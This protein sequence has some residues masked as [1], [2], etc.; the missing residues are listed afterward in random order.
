MKIKDFKAKWCIEI[1]DSEIQRNLIW[2]ESFKEKLFESVLNNKPIGAITIFQEKGKSYKEIIDG[3]QRIYALESF[4]K[5]ET[6]YKKK[7][8]N[9]YDEEKFYNYDLLIQESSGS[10]EDKVEL[11]NKINTCVEPLKPFELLRAKYYGDLVNGLTDFVQ[12]NKNIKKVL[13]TNSRGAN[14]LTVLSL[15]CKGLNYDDFLKLHKD[16]DINIHIKLPKQ[17]FLFV[18]EVF[19]SYKDVKILLLLAQQ[20]LKNKTEFIRNRDDINS[21]IKQMLKTPHLE[22]WDKLSE[23]ERILDR[24]VVEKDPKRTFS[25]EIKKELWDKQTKADGKVLCAL[26][27]QTIDSID[28]AEVDHIKAWSNGGTTDIKNAQLVHKHCNILKSN[29]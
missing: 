24:Y 7:Y 1:K 27:G 9:E 14:E 6:S 17:L 25:K 12:N 3:K 19:N 13:G 20:Y 5:G 18:D 10:F 16:D 29:K 8:I 2:P 11:F 4:W 21:D 26:C 22:G 23:Y 15:I 28:D